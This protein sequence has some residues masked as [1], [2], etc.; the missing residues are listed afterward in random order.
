MPADLIDDEHCYSVTRQYRARGDFCTTSIRQVE[1][2][3]RLTSAAIGL[4]DTLQPEQ[5]E[6]SD[7]SI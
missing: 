2:R 6:S 7:L 5:P 1:V 3:R 4:R